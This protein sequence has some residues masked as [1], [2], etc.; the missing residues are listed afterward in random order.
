MPTYRNFQ[1]LGI[2]STGKLSKLYAVYQFDLASKFVKFVYER[3]QLVYLMVTAFKLDRA[4]IPPSTKF[5]RN[6]SEIWTFPQSQRC[7]Y[8]KIR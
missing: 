6:A 7:S 2:P 5:F 3:P 8:P 4:S 1:P